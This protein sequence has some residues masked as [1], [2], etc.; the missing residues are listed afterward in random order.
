MPAPASPGALA[1]CKTPHRMR[2]LEL[3]Q[4]PG[5][6]LQIFPAQLESSA[7]RVWNSSSDTS[8]WITGVILDVAGGA[9]M[10]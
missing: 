5:L 2:G 1:A 6:R 8:G 3:L 9:V 4:G 7:G 10:G